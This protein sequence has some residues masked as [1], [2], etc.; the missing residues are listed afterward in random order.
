[1]TSTD[2]PARDYLKTKPEAMA[3]LRAYLHWRGVAFKDIIGRYR[4][5]TS[6]REFLIARVKEMLS[7]L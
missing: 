3:L 4:T 6:M 2:T 1:M 5:R 7:A